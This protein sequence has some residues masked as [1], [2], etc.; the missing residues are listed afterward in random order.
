MLLTCFT[1]GTSVL[2]GWSMELNHR[3][4][5]YRRCFQRRYPAPYSRYMLITSTRLFSIDGGSHCGPFDGHVGCVVESSISTGVLWFSSPCL[6]GE[7]EGIKTR[8]VW[9]IIR[10]LSFQLFVWYSFLLFYSPFTKPW[11]WLGGELCPR[12]CRQVLRSWSVVCFFK[13][14]MKCCLTKII[15]KNA[16]QIIKKRCY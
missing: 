8:L 14:W 16:P 2:C 6:H 9:D 4:V 11:G 12:S 3:L 7:S 15:N 10:Y 1:H 13:L 5:R